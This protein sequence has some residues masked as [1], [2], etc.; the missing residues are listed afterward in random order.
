LLFFSICKMFIVFFIVSYSCPVSTICCANLE[1][2]LLFLMSHMCSLYFVLNVC[3]V[4]P[5]YS[6]SRSDI[7]AIAH[8]NTLIQ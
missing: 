5:I 8:Q 7:L 6:N 1:Y 2:C 3:P 4:C